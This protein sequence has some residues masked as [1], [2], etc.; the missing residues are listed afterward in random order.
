[1][2]NRILFL[3]RSLQATGGLVVLSPTIFAEARSDLEPP[4]PVGSPMVLKAT[5]ASGCLS[6]LLTSKYQEAL[7]TRRPGQSTD[8]IVR[9]E[10]SRPELATRPLDIP[11]DEGAP[12]VLLTYRKEAEQ[13][14]SSVDW[15]LCRFSIPEPH[16]PTD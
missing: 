14:L 12:T 2:I 7:R 10:A 8:S 11:V 5:V 6:V 1:M 13:R 9:P 16:D 15:P 3:R 4:D